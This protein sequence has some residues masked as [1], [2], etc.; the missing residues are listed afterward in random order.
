MTRSSSEKPDRSGGQG[1][2]SEGLRDIVLLAVPQLGLMLCHMGM[3]LTDVTICGLISPL[4]QASLGMVGQLFTLLM[5]LASLVGSGCLAAV[6][7]ALGMGLERRAAR[8]AGMIVALA[9]SV[10]LLIAVLTLA[11]LPHVLNFMNVAAQMRPVAAC[12]V[13]AYCFQLPFYYALIMLNSVFRAYRMVV[14]PFITM[15]GVA[16]LNLAGSALFGLGLFGLPDLGY[17]GVAWTTFVSS[18]FGFFWNVGAAVRHGI[19]CRQSLPELRWARR[20]APYLFRVGSASA[21]GNVAGHSGNLLVYS[22]LSG[23]PGDG[24]SLLAALTLGMTAESALLF[25]FA[26]LGMSMAILSGHMMGGRRV[27]RLRE[28]G[29]RAALTAFCLALCLAALIFVARRDIG[30]LLSSRAETGNMLALFLGCSCIS[31]PARCAC[32]MVHGIFSGVG[33]TRLSCMVNCLCIWGCYVPLA[34]LLTQFFDG[35]ASGVFLA[36][37]SGH[38]MAFL[39]TICLFRGKKWLEYGMRRRQNG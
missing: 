33:A 34:F 25:P 5:L 29:G 12:F 35:G 20:A 30:E 1:T 19:L 11:A 3:S 39:W 28:L 8:Y 15:V 32:M 18:L 21:L 37:A 14:M 9:L 36:M 31:L 27:S 38:W 22:L 6:S 13:T 17:A 10:G 24:V 4:A 16:L 23:L 7:Q 26:A 2:A